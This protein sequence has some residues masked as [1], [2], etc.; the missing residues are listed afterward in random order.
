M[1]MIIITSHL[2]G[3]FTGEWAGT[4]RTSRGYLA[5][6]MTPII[7]ALGVLALGHAK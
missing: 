6:G 4:G 2:A 3:F 5:L 1:G 7:Y